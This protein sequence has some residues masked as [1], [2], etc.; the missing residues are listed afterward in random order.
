MLFF[1]YAIC[2]MTPSCTLLQAYCLCVD[3]CMYM[4]ALCC[5]VLHCCFICADVVP[6]LVCVWCRPSLMVF[7]AVSVV[8]QKICKYVCMWNCKKFKHGY[9]LMCWLLSLQV[10]F[11]FFFFF[12]G[13][14]HHSFIMPLSVSTSIYSCLEHIFG[15]VHLSCYRTDVCVSKYLVWSCYALPFELYA[16]L[17]YIPTL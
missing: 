3:W 16:G 15:L 10:E 12:L 2:L 17:A 11:F 6:H 1:I 5:V 4:H 8:S 13:S 14:S 9:F 7:I